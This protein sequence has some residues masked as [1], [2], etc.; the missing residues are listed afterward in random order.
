MEPVTE[1]RCMCTPILDECDTACTGNWCSGSV[2]R[3]R[4]QN[5]ACHFFMV[6]CAD[7][8]VNESSGLLIFF[9]VASECRSELL[10]VLSSFLRPQLCLLYLIL[11]YTLF[12]AL[13][14]AS[15][16]GALQLPVM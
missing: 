1:D 8:S 3:T 16:L 11:V 10:V 6:K 12:M 15:L 9:T 5:L 7:Q 4:S 2:F 13:V 14:F